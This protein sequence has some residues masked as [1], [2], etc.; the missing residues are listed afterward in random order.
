MKPGIYSSRQYLDVLA[1][2]LQDD[3]SILATC[4]KM[5]VPVFSP[6]LN[7][8]SIG[9]GLQRGPQC[10]HGCQLASGGFSHQNDSVGIHAIL[11]SMILH[12]R[13][14]AP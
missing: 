6:A 11:R 13:D 9:I 3:Q 4:H 5:G 2:R 1:S 12:K 10:R 8:S 14:R 7:D